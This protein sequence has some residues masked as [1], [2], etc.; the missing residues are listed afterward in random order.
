M[1][2][3]R[4]RLPIT[5]IYDRSTKPWSWVFTKT[6]KA[7]PEQH[8]AWD[9]R[10]QEFRQ[11]VL[12][13][14][15]QTL[16]EELVGSRRYNELT[17]MSFLRQSPPPVEHIYTETEAGQAV[18]AEAGPHPPQPS[19]YQRQPAQADT[20]G[21][22]T[23]VDIRRKISSD[24]SRRYSGFISNRD[25]Y[26]A[27][28]VLELLGRSTETKNPPATTREECNNPRQNPFYGITLGDGSLEEGSAKALDEHLRGIKFDH[29]RRGPEQ[30]LLVC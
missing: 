26:K 6:S 10:C 2:I 8:E 5:Y 14:L 20:R 22:P 27:L 23:V 15:D 16:L 12:L 28:A 1:A 11:D 21:L 13:Q 4:C 18:E 19:G 3:V 24:K 25:Y 9:E 29:S 7:D 30:K 17:Y